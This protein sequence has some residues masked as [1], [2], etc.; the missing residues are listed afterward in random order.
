MANIFDSYFN[1]EDE[2]EK[3]PSQKA[4]EQV[5]ATTTEV[6]SSIF[7]PYFTEEEYKPQETM[8]E[9]EEE[10]KPSLIER[11]V[12]FVK[13]LFK[14]KE[15]EPQQEY[16][17]P[18]SAFGDSGMLGIGDMT[19]STQ[20]QVS[21][22]PFNPIREYNVFLNNGLLKN[23]EDCRT[24][25]KEEESKDDP[26]YTKIDKWQDDVNDINEALALPV[27][28]WRS[29]GQKYK[30]GKEK[31]FTRDFR[32]AVGT[33]A[34]LAASMLDF[35]SKL[36]ENDP[37][38][39]ATQER[40]KQLEK[41][42]KQE[43]ADKLKEIWG[44]SED[45]DLPTRKYSESIKTWAA[46]ITPKNP[47]V[48]DMLTDGV[49]STVPFLIASIAS[50]GGA[51]EMAFLEAAGEAGSVYEANRQQGENVQDASKKA[52][53]NF[54]VNLVIGYFTDKVAFF[55]DEDR[56][57]KRALN[58]MTAEGVQEGTQQLN[59]NYFSGRP[60]ME[61]VLE[62]AGIG[63]FAGGTLSVTIAGTGQAFTK[64]IE[65]VEVTGAREEQAPAP[66]EEPAPEK[67]VETREPEQIKEESIDKLEPMFEE[68]PKY[69]SAED[70]ADVVLGAKEDQQ[71]GYMKGNEIVPRDPV[72][73]NSDQFQALEKSVLDE[74]F[75]EPIRVTVRGDGVIET[76]EGS[77]RVVVAQRNDLEVPVIVNTG[78]IEGLPI[79]SEVY[80]RVVEKAPAPAKE[81]GV[82]EP[83][84]L[85]EMSIDERVEKAVELGRAAYN[86][87]RSRVPAQDSE[88]TALLQG[89]PMGEDT[90]RIMRSWIDEYDRLADEAA[91]KVL[92][93]P[94]PK[95]EKPV[96]EKKPEKPKK[97]KPS[98]KAAQRSKEV[99]KGFA[100]AIKNDATEVKEAVEFKHGKGAKLADLTA[101]QI[102]DIIPDN[103]FIEYTDNVAKKFGTISKAINYSLLSDRQTFIYGGVSQDVFT[104]GYLIILDKAA[105]KDVNEKNVERFRKQEV[106]DLQKLGGLSL[107][108]A[109]KEADR[110]IKERLADTS[111]QYPAYEQI[112]P[113][114]E[115]MEKA[116]VAAITNWGGDIIYVLQSD[117]H[118]AI[119]NAHRFEFLKKKFP[120]DNF[121]IKGE[122]EPVAFSKKTKVN[123][124]VM[125][126]S[127]L[128]EITARAQQAQDK[129]EPE[130]TKP[131]K[132][133]SSSQAD[134]GSE[135]ASLEEL[136]RTFGNVPAVKF[137]EIVRMAR[138]LTQNPIKVKLPRSRFGGVPRGVARTSGEFKEIVLNPN[139]FKDAELMSK[140]LAHELGHI[141]DYVPDNTYA[142]GNLL[143]KIASLR[144]F[145]RHTFTDLKTESKLDDLVRKQKDLQQQR[146]DLKDADGKLPD[147]N[148]IKDELVLGKLKEVNKEIKKL[149]KS[150]TLKNEEV[151]NELKNLTQLWKPF[152]EEA[153]PAFTAYRYSG[154]ELYADAISVLFN[155]PNLLE[156]TAPNFYRGFFENLDAKPE[157]KELFFQTWNLIYRGDEAL[158]S[159][160]HK[161][162]REMFEKGE[163]IHKAL[164]EEKR[165]EDKE[166]VFRLKYELID[167]NQRMI[168]KVNQAVAEG[169]PVPDDMNPVYWLESH[170][171]VGGIVKNYMQ[172][173][174]QPLYERT[175]ANSLSWEDVGEV[176]FLER[177][178]KERGD[179][180]NPVGYIRD[181]DP[182][183][184]DS[185]KDDLPEGIE[186]KS[187]TDQ[188]RI[189]K[190]LYAD[191]IELDSGR[192]KYQELIAI[193]PKGLANPLGI[194]SETAQEQLDYLQKELGD[195]KWM[196]LQSIVR[197]FR[198]ATNKI[199]QMG[200][201]EGFWKEDLIKDMEANPAYATF[202]VLDYLQE[203]IPAGIKHQ[204]GTLKEIANPA[205]ATTL[206]SVSII[207]AIERNKVKKKVVDFMKTNFPDEIQEARYTFT[208]KA[209]IPLEP[210]NKKLALFTTIEDGSYKGY[211]VD[212]YIAK[213]ME[214]TSIGQ[215]NAVVEVFKL[216]NSRLFRPMFI[217]FNVGFQTFNLFRDFFRFYKNVP[218]MTIPRALKAYAKALKPAAKRAWNIPDET[219]SEMEKNKMLSVTYND[220]IRG[221]TNEDARIDVILAKYG[222][223]ELKGK[224]KVAL[225]KPITSILD[226]IEKTGNFVESIPK[227]AGYQELQG[228]MPTEKLGHV[229]RTRV[230][231]PDFL[232]KGASYRTY[233]E[234]FLFSNAIKEGIRTDLAVATEPETR[235]GWWFKTA[236]I[237]ILPKMLMWAALAG[238]FGDKLKDMLE[239]VSEYDKT[240]YT[241]IPLGLDKN[242]KTVYLRVPQDETGRLV[243]GIF[244]KI[245]R[246]SN[247][248]R[249]ILQDLSDLLSFTGG[250]L[251]SISPLVT[252]VSATSQY[253]AGRNPYDFFRGRPVVPDYEW[254]AGGMYRLKPFVNWQLQTL[255]L[256]N[257][258]RGYVSQQAPQTKTW[259]QKLIEAPVASNIVG[260]WLKVSDYGKTEKNKQIVQNEEQETAKRLL[261]ERRKVE[262]AVREYESGNPSYSRRTSIERQLVKDVV[263]EPPYKGT[264]KAKAT[265]TAKKF[266]IAIIKGASDTNVTSLIYANTNVEKLAL[267]REIKKDMSA[268]EFRK[269]KEMVIR[270]GIVS[271]GVFVDLERESR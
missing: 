234:I 255:G 68:A 128:D 197:D 195:H 269:L 24:E 51:L 268:P 75:K 228:K 64:R 145:L 134:I 62:S 95:E 69:V 117:N 139:I 193:M 207:R 147:K 113:K 175:K 150:P 202:Q 2:E 180:V 239:G 154:N 109:T 172:E 4:A 28:S 194:T 232:R 196:A 185:I 34:N 236:K 6:E 212:P 27:D 30:V 229:I 26:D 47:D 247:N 131:Q 7:S 123:A 70:F 20:I 233:N 23:L 241:I 159:E 136:R 55:S 138:N 270:E 77:N 122:A 226:V 116:K 217:T 252:S 129:I 245:M 168:D 76:V 183:L 61:G 205:D 110:V 174:I 216:F 209:R 11:G 33:I 214:Y 66:V 213:T 54:L 93:E 222:A 111:S 253:L 230:G 25:I 91:N 65:P 237:N 58:S 227:V 201:E 265:N 59:S 104:D 82:A 155:M 42:G 10:K 133:N 235:A 249:P 198:E 188:L 103:N 223:T 158:Q 215:A 142:R 140:V 89:I 261:E 263:G 37:M 48:L 208:G 135:Y 258:W 204:I 224:K 80:N 18:P 100:E 259:T 132:V 221:A 190:E 156:T 256:G 173:N 36:S 102:A 79:I 83:I 74:G 144:T 248:N 182:M 119:V 101:A 22:Q 118:T 260:R 97:P 39:Q 45:R 257:V 160:R 49:V 105:A 16:N 161:E 85:T 176:L 200:K 31:E 52:D 148:K 40:V 244:W 53:K 153:S 143:G 163:D 92:E 171:Y 218:T 130:P 86:E 187:T 35:A 266:R 115:D 177:V 29:T 88:L 166:Y 14:K 127:G 41:E 186:R 98:E 151:F 17:P 189:L 87:N 242:G 254:E 264:R 94:T 192:S 184:Y 56:L 67:P 231:S 121:Y 206:K 50:G 96:E 162:I 46:D 243:G 146:R 219:I 73:V 137:P 8:K 78:T 32:S 43:E 164:L 170:N 60:I 90:Q 165:M 84:P 125:P 181:L 210:K 262:D 199:T 169:K 44:F 106:K 57:F 149:R 141:T 108:E 124:L 157:A 267:L 21:D 120:D 126:L 63:S 1:D 114:I 71:I 13:S 271:K 203:W 38:Y 99:G 179:I 107:D 12:S 191:M 19:P 178:I 112:I 152:D 246:A 251:P 225:L 72:D 5:K 240:N 3:L 15:P 81:R 9:P 220:V 250:Q 211:Y 167:K 238:L